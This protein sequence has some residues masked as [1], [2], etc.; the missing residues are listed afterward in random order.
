MAVRRTPRRF[1]SPVR[2]RWDQGGPRRPNLGRGVAWLAL[3]ALAMSTIY[4]FVFVFL[5][6]LKPEPEYHAN[7]LG[8]PSDPTLQFLTRAWVDGR[9][10]DYAINSL[11]VVGVAIALTLVVS[12]PAGFALAQLR[13]PGRGLLLFGVI[14][15]MMLPS[16][17]LMVPI[18]TT[19]VHLG[20]V[21]QYLGLALVYASLQT[22]FSVYLLTSYFRGLPTEIIEAAKC[23][24][25]S[26]FQVL[27]SVGLPLAR[28]AILTL[29]T[30]NFLWLWNELL[31][32]LIILQQDDKR[33]LTV[34]L[35]VLQG[36]Q[37]TP[38]PLFA[39]MLV[40]SVIPSLLVFVALQRNLARGLLAGAVK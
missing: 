22:P 27:K 34:G 7:P 13:F 28:P 26:T 3:V 1:W 5:T 36:K 14:G 39:A 6:A 12:A 25:A 40:W 4:P 9:I 16:S 11:I 24:G 19:I 33:T 23:D 32:G 35:A 2:D 30:L 18:F 21:N 37:T 17:V 29:T 15:M 38:V 10:P 31:F 8:I 20:L